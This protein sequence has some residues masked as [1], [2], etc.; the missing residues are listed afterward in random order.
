EG[1]EEG[2]GGGDGDDPPEGD[3]ESAEEGQEGEGGQRRGR[4]RPKKDVL[5][6]EK[7][8]WREF[9][10]C[11]ATSRMFNKHSDV[12]RRLAQRWIAIC[13]SKGKAA[14][15]EAD[16][17]KYSLATKRL[18]I[19]EQGIKLHRKRI[20]SGSSDKSYAE[21]DSGFRSLQEFAR[22]DPA[23]PFT[24][25]LLWDM[26][27]TLKASLGRA[28][29]WSSTPPAVW[30]TELSARSLQESFGSLCDVK[31]KQSTYIKQLI[32]A[33]L[34]SRAPL[35]EVKHVISKVIECLDALP[36]GPPAPQLDRDLS[37][38]LRSMSLAF[39]LPAKS[40]DQK[41]RASLQ[42][43]K[44]DMADTSRL[45]NLLMQYPAQGKPLVDAFDTR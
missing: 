20:E 1:A 13:Q 10:G 8:M 28:S 23:Q 18:M 21:W 6:L 7:D 25:E 2:T 33:A 17:T 44:M 39:T 5:V 42:Q 29:M 15:A 36:T 30:A 4:G 24:C 26:R 19:I 27:L 38:E 22:A 45:L 40:F 43:A 34:R 35:E 12:T 41:V 9:M 11:D 14:K 32:A 3:D 37:Q 31:D 16:Q